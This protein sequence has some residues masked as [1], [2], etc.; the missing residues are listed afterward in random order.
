MQYTYSKVVWKIG[1]EYYGLKGQELNLFVTGKKNAIHL[2][3]FATTKNKL[4]LLF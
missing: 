3:A 2:I 4:Y 1:N